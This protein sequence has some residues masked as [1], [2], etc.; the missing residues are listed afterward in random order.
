[1]IAFGCFVFVYEKRAC[2]HLGQV[3]DLGLDET[4]VIL[5]N[6]GLRPAVGWR[7]RVR[8]GVV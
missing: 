8:G 7:R 6:R 2:V 4:C 1:M 3:E 5:P